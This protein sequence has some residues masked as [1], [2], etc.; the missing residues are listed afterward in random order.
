[1]AADTAGPTQNLFAGR[2]PEPLLRAGVVVLTDTYAHDPALRACGRVPLERQGYLFARGRRDDGVEGWFIVDLAA[3]VSMVARAFLP[4]GQ[5][6]RP[7]S[8]SEHSAAGTR[9]LPYHP[10]GATGPIATVL[11][12]GVLPGIAFSDLRLSNVEMTV[13]ERMPESFGRPVAGILGM[14]VLRGCGRLVLDLPPDSA[15]ATLELAMAGGWRDAGERKAAQQMLDDLSAQA[16]R[17]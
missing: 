7:L 13:L 14:D 11:G 15:R 8:M 2:L 10:T 4:A 5:A 9:S 1:V 16:G 17:R 6:I 12:T 3:S